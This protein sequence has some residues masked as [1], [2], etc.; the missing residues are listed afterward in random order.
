MHLLSPQSGAFT[1]PNHR[2]KPEIFV[3]F[4]SVV[5]PNKAPT[6]IGDVSINQEEIFKLHRD[7]PTFSVVFVHANAVGNVKGLY[8]GQDAHTRVAF[9]VSG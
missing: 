7:H 5:Q 2:Y 6:S 3:P 1:V 4:H 8:F 9:L